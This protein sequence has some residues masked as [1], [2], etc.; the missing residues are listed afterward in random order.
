MDTDFH[1]LFIRVDLWLSVI[2]YSTFVILHSKFCISSR[3]AATSADSG[4]QANDVVLRFNGVPKAPPAIPPPPH[5]GGGIR[6]ARPIQRRLLDALALAAPFV[7]S[8]GETFAMHCLNIA[9]CLFEQGWEKHDLSASG[10]YIH[11]LNI[12]KLKSFIVLKC[13]ALLEAR[14]KL[15]STAVAAIMASP[16]RN[17]E[18]RVYSSI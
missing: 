7:I 17:P 8:D 18:T 1:R 9:I 4:L 15:F 13:L 12:F 11:G 14:V 2:R 3:S 10:A 5:P 6:F 16:E